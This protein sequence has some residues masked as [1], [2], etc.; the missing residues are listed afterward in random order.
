M[1]LYTSRSQYNDQKSESNIYSPSKLNYLSNINKNIKMKFDEKLI[2]K[3]LPKLNNKEYPKKL[4]SFLTKFKCNKLN[5]SD[6]SL[7]TINS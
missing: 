2:N 3:Q 1:H 6:N 5:I 4:T 7:N